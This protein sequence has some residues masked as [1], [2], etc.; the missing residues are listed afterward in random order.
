MVDMW[1][2][3]YPTSGG[4]MALNIKSRETYRL[5][6]ELAKETGER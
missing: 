3:F 2:D 4:S 5:V 6:Q 1:V